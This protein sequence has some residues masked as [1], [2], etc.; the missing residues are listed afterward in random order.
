MNR[1]S[2]REQKTN[3]S[4]RPLLLTRPYLLVDSFL[5]VCT[6]VSGRVSQSV[7]SLCWAKAWGGWGGGT[8]YGT[9]LPSDWNQ[10]DRPYQFTPQEEVPGL[11]GDHT[12]SWVVFTKTTH[13]RLR[14]LRKLSL[15]WT[16][17]WCWV[18]FS[19]HTNTL[20]HTFSLQPHP[21]LHVGERCNSSPVF[22]PAF[23]SEWLA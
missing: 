15:I 14:F 4:M 18:F 10:I 22:S 6:S 3:Q 20:A 5:S 8:L 21:L 17:W 13:R 16:W 1:K 23:T 2:D 11:Q 12:R 19:L 7:I 9:S